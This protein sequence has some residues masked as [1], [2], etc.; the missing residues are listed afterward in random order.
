[1]KIKIQQRSLTDCLDNVIDYRGKTPKK[2][3]LEWS[4]LGYRAIS[5]NNVKFDGLTKID[6]INCLDEAGYKKW[7]KE[8]VKKGDL[9]L[10]SEA[11]AGQV[12]LWMN[13]EKIV[14]S[15][16][17]FALRTKPDVYNKY[18]K[19]Y[20][21][22][23]IG[24]F[25]INKNTSGSTVFG[26]SAKMFD[27][28]KINLPDY[29]SQI[30]I[31]D[32]LYL[33]DSKIEL[34]NRINAELEAMAKTL[35]DYWFV[36]FDFPDKNGKPYKTSGGKMVWNEELKREIPEGWEV[37]KIGKILKTSL[38]GT[39]STKV[40]EY[41]ENGKISWLNSGEIANFPIIDS[42]LKITEAAIKNS[43]TDLLPK[44]SVMLSITRHLRPS[45]LGI[46]AC[47]NQSVIG[48]LEKDDIKC[49]FLY[50]YLQNEI[51]RLMEMRSGAQQPHI[52]K[53]IVD[54]SFILLPNN[55]TEILKK[56]NA[57]AGHFYESIINKAFQNQKL[58][59]LRDWL[60]PM[61]MNGQVKV[62]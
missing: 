24:Q 54:E 27:F 6:S 41:W 44:G 30:S 40:K 34:N 59:E 39:P 46:D 51:P 21:Q 3:G 53:E 13:D 62:N 19:Y 8:E 52:N 22:S 25:E 26:I 48:I 57:Q 10:T 60:L 45:I 36:Q 20:L 42:E 11:P 2:L 47:A 18:L 28:I 43:A 50:P 37:K 56:Y 29:D 1:M 5:A 55:E 12:M 7:M 58:T 16:R 4:N 17:L 32:I 14:L 61:L 33:I 31:G 23:N 15:Q 38:G 49:Y 9:L 35:Y